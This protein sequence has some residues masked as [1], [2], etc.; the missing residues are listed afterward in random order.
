MQPDTGI[1]DYEHLE[2]LACRFKPKIII[3][4]TSAYSRNIDYARFREVRLEGIF[5]NR[6]NWL[7]ECF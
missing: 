2:D 4:G 5:V 3:A 7:L 1:I 6:G